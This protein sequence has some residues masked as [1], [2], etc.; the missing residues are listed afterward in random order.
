LAKRHTSFLL[1]CWRL[2]SGA[3]R[4]EIEHIPT[5]GR[6][7]VPSF[8]LGLEWLEARAK[9]VLDA[10]GTDRTTGRAEVAPGG[11]DR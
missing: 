1:R 8:P 4:I 7:V 11:E 10:S 2:A 9:E 6:T 5:G 3:R